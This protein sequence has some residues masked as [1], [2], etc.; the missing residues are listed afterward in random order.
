MV[1]L[2]DI[3]EAIALRIK[4]KMEA[5]AG[6]IDVQ[7][8]IEGV[9]APAV[10]VSIDDGAYERTA[11]NTFSQEITCWIDIVFSNVQNE[12]QRR[13]GIY[14]IL[15]GIVQCL[16]LQD[17]GLKMTPLVPKSFRNITSEEHKGHGLIIYALE[18]KTKTYITRQDDEAIT[19]LFTVGL[20]YYLKPGDE[21]VDAIDL[22]TVQTPPAPEGEA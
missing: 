5:A 4:T 3:E 19:D 11:S 2:S 22:V 20:N 12:A 1:S 10:Y 17:L 7:R 9:P 14:P 13:K 21:T 6:H 16:F 8:G 18:M 15:Q